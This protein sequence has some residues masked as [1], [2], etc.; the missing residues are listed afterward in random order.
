MM[1]PKMELKSDLMRLSV[2]HPITEADDALDTRAEE[3]FRIL[4]E[5][6]EVADNLTDKQ[7]CAMVHEAA[8][9]CGFE[10]VIDAWVSLLV[11]TEKRVA[12]IDFPGFGPRARDV[13]N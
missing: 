5:V 13:E 6:Q 9:A 2:E 11:V 3:L 12:S 4:E 8:Q 10:N 1:K 7:F